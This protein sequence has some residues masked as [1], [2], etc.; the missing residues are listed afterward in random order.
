MLF[1][2]CNEMTGVRETG[3]YCDLT[4]FETQ[5]HDQQLFGLADPKRS[6]IFIG[7]T[8]QEAPEEPG[9][10]LGGDIDQTAE[11]IYS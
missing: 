1:K 2:D 10:V 11:F 7:R 4:D 6:E 9:K 3:S 8:V 5:F